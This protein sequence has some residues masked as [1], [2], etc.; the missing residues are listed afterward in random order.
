MNY[1]DLVHIAESYANDF[2]NENIQHQVVAIC[3]KNGKPIAFGINQKRYI[4]NRSV[5][6]CH[7]HAEIDLLRKLNNKIKGTKF[8]LYRFNNTNHPDAREPKNG[9]PCIFC[10]HILKDCGVSR[11]Y[12]LNDQNVLTVLKNRDMISVIA[13][14]ATITHHFI[15]RFG[16]KTN[17]KQ[18]KYVSI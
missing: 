11:V 13:N 7:C 3:V 5:F 10:Q 15:E 8:F 14:P 4:K 2:R 12:F 18:E 17:L 1:Y 6:D 9:K 16:L